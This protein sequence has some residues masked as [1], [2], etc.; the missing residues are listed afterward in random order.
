MWDHDGR[1][2]KLD[3]VKFMD[4]GPLGRDSAFNV[5]A[6]GA[7]KGS[8]CVWLVGWLK[9]DPKDGPPSATQKCLTSL[10]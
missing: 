1:S 5:A 8:Q 10:G 4:M 3:Q 2:I 7:R 6:P 9:H